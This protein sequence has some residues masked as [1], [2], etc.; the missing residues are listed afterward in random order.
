VNCG[1]LDPL[2]PAGLLGNLRELWRFRELLWAMTERELRIRYKNSAL[3]FFWSL[4]NPLVTI[5][6]MTVVFKTFLRN[7]SDGYSAHVLAAYLPY[8]F[9][10]LSILDSSQSV[11][12]AMPMVK[13]VY[14][15][16]EILPLSTL[17]ANLVHFVL[18]LGVFFLYLLGLWAATGFGE[19]PF[20]WR[21]AV[22]PPLVLVLA[23]FATGVSLVVS[24]LNVF[25][26]DVKYVVGVLLYI[27]FFLTPVMYFVE[28]V[29]YGLAGLSW[30]PLA[31]L[32]YHLNPMVSLTT[33]FR[34]A[35]VQPGPVDVGGVEGRVPPLAFHWGL[36]AYAAVASVVVL[37]LGLSVFNRLKWRFVERP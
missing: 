21:I 37:L 13:K 28:N 14:F 30:R 18:A 26:E 19:S 5:A 11:I 2:T 9:V 17:L 7:Q 4:L 36:F 3:G 6:V 12:A 35:L 24:A 1:I 20:T 15:P 10:N 34:R 22:L 29:W 31:F 8:M 33:A 16:R 23:L 32:A 27:G 25:Y